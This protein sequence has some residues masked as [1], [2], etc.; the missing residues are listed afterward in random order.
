M[1]EKRRIEITDYDLET[2]EISVD[3]E[4]GA[5]LVNFNF[6]ESDL[7]M[8]K[9]LVSDLEVNWDELNIEREEEG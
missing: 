6:K 5:V 8:L 9:K 4:F 1:T 3:F 2:D 7:P